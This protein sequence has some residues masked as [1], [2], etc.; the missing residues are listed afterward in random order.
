MILSALSH[1]VMHIFI[2]A[3]SGIL[4]IISLLTYIRTKRTKFLYI[5]GAFLVFSF[6][7]I[8][9]AVNIILFGADPLTML[10][11]FFDLIIL[12]LFAIGIFK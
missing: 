9:L 1:N 11:H 5:C 6:K 10:T 12:A 2:A 4:L 7:E 8:L 3:L